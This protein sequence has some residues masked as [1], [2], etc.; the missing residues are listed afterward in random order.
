MQ[1][2]TSLLVTQNVLINSLEHYSL[3]EEVLT[4]KSYYTT[5]KRIYTLKIL[6]AISV[7]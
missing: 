3:S 4:V 6:P 5:Y 7:K 2:V 1:A